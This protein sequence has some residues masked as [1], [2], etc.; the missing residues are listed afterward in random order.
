M[1]SFIDRYD[2]QITRVFEI[3]PALTS[4]LV[5]LSPIWLGLLW[6]TAVAFVLAFLAVY[7]VYRALVHTVGILVGYRRW[8]A[9]EKVDWLERCRKLDWS[10]LPEP[11]TIPASLAGLK[12]LVL[13]PVVNESH[14]VLEMT[15]ASIAASAYPKE[16]LF[17]VLPI[18]ERGAK[19][20]KKSLQKLAAKYGQ[21]LGTVWTFVHPAGIEGE[22]V[23][24]GAPNRTWGAKGAIKKIKK[25][26]LKVEDFV[27][28]TFDADTVIHPQFLARL[29]YAY[30]TSDRRLHKFYS[31]AIYHFNNNLWE[32]PSLMRI[33]ANMVTLATLSSRALNLD[34]HE[35]FSC[36]AV[37]LPTLIDADFW[38]VTLI[39]DTVFYWRA[40]FARDGD[41]EA[42]DFFLPISND[43]VQG[44]DFLDSH[45]SLYKQLFRWGWGSVTTPIALRG[46][47]RNKKVPIRIKI[48]W[49]YNK[50]ERHAIW[51][52]VVFL[53]TFGYALLALVS[54]TIRQ[55]AIGYRL[56]EVISFVLTF[57]LIFILPSSIYRQKIIKPMPKG[58]PLWKKTLAWLEGPL[59]I[60]N[61]LTFSF[62]PGLEAETKMMFGK[63][64]KKLYH[65]S[66]IRSKV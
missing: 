66:K 38:D 56:P 39:D 21:D 54:E 3:L 27:F 7:W 40:F 58:W 1:A 52:T 55:T 59:V 18:E 48:L 65:T 63:H 46:F 17:V 8:Q 14:A 41:F 26:G 20:V 37:P 11:A 51:R 23:G 31:P 28:T 2:R 12:H 61:L 22:L 45:K 25:L 29:T 32:V 49:T 53:I 16:N 13:I 34:L 10:S 50:F 5:L 30:L 6:P 24:G 4:W 43:A 57:G 15:L 35:T 60:L 44:K 47:L 42:V 64:Y 9:E 33:E 19:E 62:I 36:Y